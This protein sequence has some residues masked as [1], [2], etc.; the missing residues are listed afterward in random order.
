MLRHGLV[1]GML[2]RS[3]FGRQ[4][5][6]SSGNVKRPGQVRNGLPGLR[7]AERLKELECENSRLKQVWAEKELDNHI[8]R[9]ARIAYAET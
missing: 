6:I 3:Q 4:A 5:P 8:L 2:F 7:R 9:E 1:I